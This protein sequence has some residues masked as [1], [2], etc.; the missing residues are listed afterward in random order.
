MQILWILLQGIKKSGIIYYGKYPILLNEQTG[1][2]IDFIKSLYKMS[3]ICSG[4]KN[5]IEVGERYCSN[6]GQAVPKKTY[7]EMRKADDELLMQQV[8]YPK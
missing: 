3:D 7:K 1:E 2:E 4:C 5:M 8:E 6:C